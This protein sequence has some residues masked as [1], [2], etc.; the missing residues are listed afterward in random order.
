MLAALTLG[1][2]DQI[3]V[4]HLPRWLVANDRPQ[5]RESDE[6]GEHSLEIV[7]RRHIERALAA[8]GGNKA[9]AARLLG[10]DRTTLYR[11]LVRLGLHDK[12]AS[13]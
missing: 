3:G 12:A 6:S 5:P 11:K 9:E 10:I 1:A 4:E 7:E 13:G 2:E 8:A